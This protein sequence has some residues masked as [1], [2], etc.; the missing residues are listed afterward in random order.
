MTEKILQ[1]K[2]INALLAQL[3]KE[4]LSPTH[5]LSHLS[6]T[7]KNCLFLAKIYGGDKEILVAAALVHDLGRKK[8]TLHGDAS[9]RESIRFAK[10]LLKKAGFEKRQIEKICQIIT[11][12]GKPEH[13]PQ[14]LEA[15]ILKD[16][17]FL[18]GFGARGILRSFFYTAEAEE[19]LEGAI[20]RLKKMKDRVK[21]LEFRE[22]R[23]IAQNQY[24]LVPLFLNLLSRKNQ[25]W[26]T[27]P[28]RF[29]VFEGISGTGKETAAKNLKKYLQSR[30]KKVE[31]IF[32]PSPRWKE[33]VKQWRQDPIDPMVEAFL[34]VADRLD[35][36]QRFIMP[37]LK[38][39]E[40]VIS[41]R[42]Y[43]SALVYQ[44]KTKEEVA[45][46]NFLFSW[47]RPTPDRIFFFDLKPETALSRVRK[48]HRETGEEYGKFEKLKLLAQ[49][50]ARYKKLLKQIPNTTTIDAS[51][52]V[53]GVFEQVKSVVE[54]EFL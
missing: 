32:H 42:C 20:K 50:R 2:R 15:K 23:Q 37:A 31:I 35:H 26:V 9:I 21:G 46:V 38:K 14:V 10:P 29:L 25:G 30:G 3:K 45:L 12:H 36:V 43:L 54:K 34:L 52:P 22:S 33:T 8:P 17:D 7:A 48:R 44:A 11:E 40:W 4:K 53:E 6:G 28:G 18:D 19:D 39:G 51:K 49:K 5:D 24:Q 13:S 47:F 16:A 1:K 41:L 27:F